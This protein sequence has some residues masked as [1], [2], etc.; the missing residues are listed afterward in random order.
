[1]LAQKYGSSAFAM[2]DAD[3]GTATDEAAAAAAVHL[4]LS[5]GYPSAVATAADRLPQPTA[6]RAASDSYAANY[7]EQRTPSR[8]A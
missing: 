3:A 2:Y 6:A 8:T 1:M 5:A 7:I 4:P